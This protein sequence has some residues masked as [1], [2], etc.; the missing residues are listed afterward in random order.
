MAKKT[1]KTANKNAK[2]DSSVYDDVPTFLKHEP[3]SPDTEAS[4]SVSTNETKTSKVTED[5]EFQQASD[6]K[7][8]PTSPEDHPDDGVSAMRDVV[9]GATE[10]NTKG[11]KPIKTKSSEAKASTVSHDTA[12]PKSHAEKP[13]AST[14]AP[15]AESPKNPSSQFKWVLLLV[16]LN[17]MLLIGAGAA[18]YWAWQQFQQDRTQRL[19]DQRDVAQLQNSVQ[20]LQQDLQLSREQAAQLKGQ[21][22]GQLSQQ[23]A[24]AQQKLDQR[25]AK[26]DRRLSEITTTSREDWKLAEA[27]YLLRLANQRLFIEGNVKNSMALLNAADNILAEL[28]DPDLGSIRQSLAQELMTLKALPEVDV[29]G[30]YVR[31]TA[32]DSQVQ[33]LSL[34]QKPAFVSNAQV[35]SGQ[36]KTVT[37]PQWWPQILNKFYISL[38]QRWQS[39]KGLVRV[40]RYDQPVEALLSP[41]SR[42]IWLHNLRVYLA[43]AQLALLQ[44]DD[45]SY[46]Q[47]LEQFSAQLTT[48]ETLKQ[49][50][51]GQAL[52]S[53]SKALQTQP[54]KQTL[55]VLSQTLKALQLY[56]EQRHR[57]R[58]GQ[59]LGQG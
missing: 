27:E 53:E 28:N 31:L 9:V 4:S 1:G 32:M 59:S 25:L 17:L 5:S 48:Y 46:R 20:Q 41:E 47:S 8:N 52:L 12:T 22:T 7:E 54:I 10:A 35:S 43:H 40:Q 57:L 2:K 3:A 51:R 39:L 36:E 55:P 29:Q 56:G 11:T 21:L 33:Q 44:Q 34:L 49:D 18:G 23:Q 38:W 19:T 50:A 15:T 24:Q 30:I 13:K 14:E 58:D 16:L 45:M 6:V 26:Q 37:P 42:A